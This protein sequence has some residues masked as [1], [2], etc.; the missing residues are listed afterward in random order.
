MAEIIRTAASAETTNATRNQT[1]D[2]ATY[3]HNPNVEMIIDRAEICTHKVDGVQKNN[4]VPVVYLKQGTAEHCVYLRSFL[5]S[6]RDYKDVDIVVKGSFDDL[7]RTYR[8]KTIGE[9]LDAINA[10][11]GRKVRTTLT[12]YKG[13]NKNGDVQ[14][15]F[16]NGYDLIEG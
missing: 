14:D 7:V 1:F 2:L 5:K 3:Y 11:K 6:R 16:V 13:I 4:G 8:T 15:I 12:V 10:L 9:M